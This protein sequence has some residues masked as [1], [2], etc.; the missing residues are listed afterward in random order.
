VRG[1]KDDRHGWL[2][3]VPV[4]SKQAGPQFRN[5]VNLRGAI[6]S[7]LFLPSQNFLETLKALSTAERRHYLGHLGKVTF[8]FIIGRACEQSASRETFDEY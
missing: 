5:F 2:T 4:G 6:P 8:R 7:R 1:E 3:P